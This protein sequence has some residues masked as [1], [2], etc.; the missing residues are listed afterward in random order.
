MP[1]IMVNARCIGP[2]T[3]NRDKVETAL[4]NQLL[5]YSRTHRIKLGCAVA[6]FTDQHDAGIADSLN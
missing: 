3:L 1:D 4:L 5:S 6:G 2:V